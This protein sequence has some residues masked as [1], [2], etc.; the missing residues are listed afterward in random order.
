MTHHRPRPARFE[1]RH[2]RTTP[3]SRPRS[4]RLSPPQSPPR[5]DPGTNR[6]AHSIRYRLSAPA[7]RS[8]YTTSQTVPLPFCRRDRQRPVP[9]SRRRSS[10]PH[11]QMV[12]IASA[13]AGAP[14]GAPAEAVP[15]VAERG[16]DRARDDLPAGWCHEAIR[17]GT[18]EDHKGGKESCA[19]DPEESGARHEAPRRGLRRYRI[20]APCTSPISASRSALQRRARLRAGSGPPEVRRTDRIVRA[21]VN[22]RT[23]RRTAGA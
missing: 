9:R 21:P 7:R 4:P 5:S 8:R 10:G 20:A 11:R 17:L 23:Y 2:R 15:P 3:T 22:A 19:P 13:R 18:A 16:V 12:A 1:R 6:I 14:A